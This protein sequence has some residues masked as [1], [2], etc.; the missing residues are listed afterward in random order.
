MRD[1]TL[2]RAR[3]ADLENRPIYKSTSARTK[4]TG[5][6]APKTFDGVEQFSRSLQRRVY[7]EFIKARYT[8]PVTSRGYNEITTDH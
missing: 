7:D 8:V 1:P 6:Q 5:E 2:R 3:L 4:R